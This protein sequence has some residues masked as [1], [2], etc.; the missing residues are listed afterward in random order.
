[1]ASAAGRATVPVA[2]I[3][4]ALASLPR[5]AYWQAWEAETYPTCPA[6]DCP[7]PTPFAILD[8]GQLD[9][10][11]G[12]L[13]IRSASYGWQAPLRGDGTMTLDQARS[14]ARFEDRFDEASGRSGSDL[15]CCQGFTVA[16]FQVRTS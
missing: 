10:L 4:K 3:Y 15:P 7:V 2:G 8:R 1:L 6:A 14:L 13:R 12:R 9:R 11:F 5:A 16:P